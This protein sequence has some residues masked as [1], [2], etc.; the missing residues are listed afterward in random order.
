MTAKTFKDSMGD[1]LEIETEG[2]DLFFD[3]TPKERGKTGPTLKFNREDGRK[4]ASHL[5]NIYGMAGFD[6]E[7]YRYI[8]D[9]LFFHKKALEDQKEHL[10]SA[11][12]C[13]HVDKEIKLIGALES[14]MKNLHR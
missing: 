11:I 2:D 12:N 9:L 5:M 4:I 8:S 3:F 14:I 13:N 1:Y 6:E 7:V 10:K